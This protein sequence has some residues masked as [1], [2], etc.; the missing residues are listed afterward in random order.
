[1]ILNPA[2]SFLASH[3]PRAHVGLAEDHYDRIEVRWPDGSLQTE[4]F[5]GGTV[6]RPVTLVQG[7]GQLATPDSK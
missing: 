6:D 5:P 4:H 3:D 2:S 7:Q 1:R